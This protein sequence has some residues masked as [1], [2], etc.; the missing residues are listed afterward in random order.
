MAKLREV[1]TVNRIGPIIIIEG[2]NNSKVPYS[3]SVFIDCPEKV[4]IDTGAE[5]QALL[6]LKEQYGVELIVNTHYH[7][8]HT[9]HNHLFPEIPKWINPIEFEM[10]KSI[11]GIA[12]GNGVYQEWGPEGIEIFRKFVSQDWA[13]SLGGITG[14]YQYELVYRFGDIKTIFLHMPGHTK[15]YSCPYFPDF[16]I[17]F[18]GDFDMTSFG[19]WYFG[20]DGDINEFI[21]SC[22]RLLSI[23]ADTF[24]TGHHKGIFS[25]QEFEQAMGNYLAII[26]ARDQTINRYVQQGMDFEELTNIG[27]FYPKNALNN[28]IMKTWERS[29]MRKHLHRLGYKIQDTEIEYAK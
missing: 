21:D 24:I 9:L 4:L 22:N 15:G 11:E 7:P 20:T 8:D 2:P 26:D 28:L 16:G 19:P 3:R 13:N 10:V 17:V 12:K 27:I 25:R 29:G 1:L 18:V 6:T 5:P 14:T 23:N